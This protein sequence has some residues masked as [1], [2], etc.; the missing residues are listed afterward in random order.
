MCFCF[1]LNGLSVLV[2]FSVCSVV[3]IVYNPLVKLPLAP[4]SVLFTLGTIVGDHGWIPRRSLD[5]QQ[6]TNPPPSPLPP[7]RHHHPVEHLLHFN[8]FPIVLRYPPLRFVYV[9]WTLIHP[10]SMKT[11]AARIHPCIYAECITSLSTPF[12]DPGYSHLHIRKSLDR[13]LMRIRASIIQQSAAA[14]ADHTKHD[15]K[16]NDDVDDDHERDEGGDEGKR[17]ALAFAAVSG[18][19]KV[20]WLTTFEEKDHAGSGTVA[21]EGLE[22]VLNEVWN[23]SNV[24]RGAVKYHAEEYK[25]AVRCNM[26]FRLKL[27]R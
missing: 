14:I 16:G 25:T 19:C 8:A 20:D 13:E 26:D 3:F 9:S 22:E 24:W 10:S 1:A 27:S 18:N 17:G 6:P 11:S 15:K 2:S 4:A 7:S 12:S 23:T 21:R 5:V